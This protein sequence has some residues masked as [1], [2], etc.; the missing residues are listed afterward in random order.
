[1]KFPGRGCAC[2][3]GVLSVRERLSGG[4]ARLEN[5]STRSVDL[6]LNHGQYRLM[7]LRDRENLRMIRFNGEM[8]PI[9]TQLLDVGAR[10][11]GVGHEVQSWFSRFSNANGVED[12]RTVLAHCRA[13]SLALQ[14][15]KEVAIA[16]VRSASS[17]EQPSAIIAAWR[18]ALETMIQEASSAET[19]SWTVEGGQEPG[20]DTFDG[21]G[22][23]TL[24]R[25]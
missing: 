5:R 19:C 13:L 1:M 16:E 23:I 4:S 6:A 10:I 18:Y 3:A 17:D 22:D 20:N 11:A 24:R 9:W 21:G 14:T 7:G 2:E 8:L 15:R 25:I 12:S